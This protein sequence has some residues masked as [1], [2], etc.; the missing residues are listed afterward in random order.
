[1]K[2]HMG[3]PLTPRSMT[4]DY[5]ELY[6]FEFS[7]NFSGF[8]K[9][10]DATTAKR[11]K[12]GQYCQRQRCK[13]KARRTGAIFGMLL[14]RAGLSATAG[15]SCYFSLCNNWVCRSLAYR[16]LHRSQYPYFITFSVFLLLSS[17][18]FLTPALLA[19][20]TLYKR[21]SPANRNSY[22]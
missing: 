2:K 5:L 12:I 21:I 3:F 10:S 15:L 8:R 9:F 14:R 11:M 1:M 19:F 7:V 6:K 17:T 13:H 18:L 16:V 4:L 22:Y 20:R